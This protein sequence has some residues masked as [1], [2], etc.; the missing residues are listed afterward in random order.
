MS[1]T[2]VGAAAGESLAAQPK[3]TRRAGHARRGPR[4][5][6]RA[7]GNGC[8]TVSA[9]WMGSG[10]VEDVRCRSIEIPLTRNVV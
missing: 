9:Q 4:A 2:S 10:P 8:N 7:L 3:R 1:K 6:S 5:L